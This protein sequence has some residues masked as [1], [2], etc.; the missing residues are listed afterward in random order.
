MKILKVAALMLCVLALW[1]SVASA[2]S[3]RGSLT[4][5]VTDPGG[6]VVPGARVAVTNIGTGE[7]RE[8]T[9]SDVGIYSFPQLQAAPYRLGVEA[10]GLKTAT[11]NEIRIGVQVARTADM[12]LEAGAI[13]EMVTVSAEANDNRSR[14]ARTVGAANP[15]AALG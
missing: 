1:T 5:T 14:C 10:A 9:T 4:G 8:T 3:D 7:V 13:T 2:Q 15:D 6:A 11:I 12:Q